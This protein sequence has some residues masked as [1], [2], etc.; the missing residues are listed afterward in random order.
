MV[1]GCGFF[2]I[3]SQLVHGHPS[4]LESTAD[5]I[6]PSQNSESFPT[7]AVSPE[8][9]HKV[10]RNKCIF[11]IAGLH[12]SCAENRICLKNVTYPRSGGEPQLS[13]RCSCQSHHRSCF[14]PR[15]SSREVE[16]PWSLWRQWIVKWISLPRSASVRRS[17]PT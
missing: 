16:K 4:P 12:G 2:W 9:Y 8:R 10:I 17:V 14:R 15:L 6:A 11:G 1:R 13:R 3:A 5:D 7:C